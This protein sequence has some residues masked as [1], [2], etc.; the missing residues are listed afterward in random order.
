MQDLN[1]L[2][3]NKIQE[4]VNKRFEKIKEIE[5]IIIY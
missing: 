1:N 4:G 5:F 2:I 3:F